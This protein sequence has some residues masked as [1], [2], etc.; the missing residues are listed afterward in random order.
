MAA[1][2]YTSSALR[3][4]GGIDENNNPCTPK[5]HRLKP[6]NSEDEAKCNSSVVPT[7]PSEA[8]PLRSA[9]RNGRSGTREL[10]RAERSPER[11]PE[12]VDG[13]KEVPGAASKL[14]MGS[15][16][17]K[18]LRSALR[19][20]NAE[21]HVEERPPEAVPEQRPE[22]A[23]SAALLSVLKNSMPASDVS[24]K[25]ALVL[26]EAPPMRLRSA[27]RASSRQTTRELPLYDRP[28]TSPE[29]GRHQSQAASSSGTTS[30]P[31]PSLPAKPLRSA[32]KKG[33]VEM[34]PLSA[35]PQRPDP[36]P[37]KPPIADPR[38][39]NADGEPKCGS[40]GALY[41]DDGDVCQSCSV[42]KLGTRSCSKDVVC[43]ARGRRGSIQEIKRP[44]LSCSTPAVWT[45]RSVIDRLYTAIEQR[46]L[47]KT[48]DEEAV[49]RD[50]SQRIALSLKELLD[51]ECD[52]PHL[53]TV[54]DRFGE[55]REQQMPFVSIKNQT[56]V[57][58]L[59]KGKLEQTTPAILSKGAVSPL[60]GVMTAKKV[61][62]KQL[63]SLLAQHADL[64]LEAPL[65]QGPPVLPTP[66]F[67][68]VAMAHPE[69]VSLL[70]K[71]KADV[72]QAYEGTTYMGHIKQGL[73][74]VQCVQKR[75]ER[76]I[77]TM[78]GDRLVHIESL[79]D[80]ME[81]KTTGEENL[82]QSVQASGQ[83][84]EAFPRKSKSITLPAAKGTINHTQGHP[85]DEYGI[86]AEL[87]G[88]SSSVWLGYHKEK[89]FPVAIKARAKLLLSKETRL[90]DEIAIL[91]RID[92]P[93]VIKLIET[94]EDVS[95]MFLVLELCQ[96][97][98][99]FDRLTSG[100][101]CCVPERCTEQQSMYVGKQILSG[102][103][104]IHS[105]GICHRDLQPLNIVLTDERP[106]GEGKLKLTDF[107]YAKEF[108]PAFGP[109]TSKICT[110]Y[111]VAPEILKDVEDPYT[112][113]VD[114]WSAGVILY[115]VIGGSPP[116][117]GENDIDI[118]RKVRKGNLKFRPDNTWASV[119]TEA[120]E[121]LQQM[122]CKNVNTRLTSLEALTHPWFGG[123]R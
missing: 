81:G 87:G 60:K 17:P 28:Y 15:S 89:L 76:F 113:K 63:E 41:L 74:P 47:W 46:N 101:R 80:A 42:S 51:E 102:V 4:R 43:Q 83:K 79:L 105:N 11:S 52:S 62:M 109:M 73:T 57:V 37:C 36:S 116:F 120:K 50:T 82:A 45:A 29:S 25:G 27:L 99:L 8:K 68:A 30:T 111:Y 53:E 106:L 33:S 26:G 115:I 103:S 39:F 48:M 71:Y 20:S 14:N 59:D 3:Y 66:L 88:E 9:L 70:I 10:F 22:E 123:E 7:L 98:P 40:C 118:L 107:T 78:L 97:G 104:Y 122:I 75:K 5:K 95:D 72:S 67:H 21:L 61:D 54:R 114:V 93:S 23:V 34:T 18:K 12:R 32:L 6:L 110:P 94:F 84:K 117:Y 49:G 85:S 13:I 119:S 2:V 91:R 90:W 24:D 92:H 19:S 100:E 64:W 112:E 56:H 65:D 86:S 44:S 58:L 16:E 69:M 55:Q 38:N 121:L 31:R 1:P 108:G 35:P 77:G 96:G